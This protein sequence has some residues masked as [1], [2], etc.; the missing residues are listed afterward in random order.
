MG[1]DALILEKSNDT[2]LSN[3]LEIE[4][5]DVLNAENLPIPLK[6]RAFPQ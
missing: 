1:F 3:F 5:I 2:S 4:I 6:L